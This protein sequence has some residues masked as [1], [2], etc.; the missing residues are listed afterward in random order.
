LLDEEGGQLT[1]AVRRRPYAVI[2]FDEVEAHPDVFNVML[3]ILDD[4]RVTDGQGRTMDFT[5]TVL[6]LT[7]NIGSQ[8]ILDLAGDTARHTEMEAR[9]NEALWGHFR[10]EFLNRL[11]ETIIFHSLR[12]EELRQA[13]QTRDP[14]RAGDADCQSHPGRPIQRRT[15]GARGS[16]GGGERRWQRQCAIRA[17]PALPAERSGQ[18]AVNTAGHLPIQVGEA[19][20]VVGGESNRQPVPDVAPL[21][22]VAHRL[23]DQGHLRHES[24]R[25]HKVG[26][27]QLALQLAV[28][29]APGGQLAGEILNL[30]WSQR[31]G[32]HGGSGTHAIIEEAGP[33]ARCRRNAVR[34]RPPTPCSWCW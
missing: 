19:A 1:E 21:G 6:I 28:L 10:P 4:G 12:Q 5:N 8:A 32:G 15:H 25:L 16:G 29:K 2:L 14:A 33:T 26:E 23:G 18:Q 7:R 22:M 9:V 3:Q 27:T 24:E 13:A 20:G 34:R 30:L 17:A 31:D 11:D